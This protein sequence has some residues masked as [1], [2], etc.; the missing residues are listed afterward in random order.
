MSFNLPA[1]QKLYCSENKL[2]TIDIS[3]S[4][5]SRLID[6]ADNNIRDLNMKVAKIK[7]LKMQRE[8]IK[9]KY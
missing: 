7:N 2:S 4:L 1:L 9:S 8:P 6:C 3:G 5:Q